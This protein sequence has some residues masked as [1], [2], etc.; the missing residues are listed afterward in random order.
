MGGIEEARCIP[1]LPLS[2]QIL[3]TARETIVDEPYQR[4]RGIRAQEA[5]QEG[6]SSEAAYRGA[7]VR[8]FTSI[9]TMI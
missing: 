8:T 6:Q 5:D 1:A 9:K 2:Q 4:D 7:A 3:A